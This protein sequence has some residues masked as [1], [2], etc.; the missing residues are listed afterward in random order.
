MLGIFDSGIG[1]L[2]VSRA[3]KEP[4]LYLS[5]DGPF[6]D[7]AWQDICARID[8]GIHA[9]IKAG[10]TRVV[11]ACNT[12]SAMLS[13]LPPYPVPVLG[14]IEPT[15]RELGNYR[16]VG[17]LATTA[18]VESG[19]YVDA[20]ARTHPECR[21]TQVACPDLAP[22]IEAGGDENKLQC[23]IDKYLGKLFWQAGPLDCVLLACTHYDLAAGMIR[24]SMPADVTLQTQGLI[25]H[26]FFS[27]ALA[28]MW[29]VKKAGGIA[30]ARKKSRQEVGADVAQ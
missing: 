21:V 10:A 13:Q 26:R 15:V 14:I 17:I 11:L 16:R 8:A 12:A 3:V 2:V 23:A 30:A 25:M 24:R 5:G 9:L 20:I 28:G 18:T 4:F 29:D 19:A 6:G 7:L 1:G 22:L 27:E